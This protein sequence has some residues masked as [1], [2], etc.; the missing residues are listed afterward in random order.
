MVWQVKSLPGCSVV[1][2]HAVM[3]QTTIRVPR[4]ASAS[5]AGCTA[6]FSLLLNLP[7]TRNNNNSNN[8]NKPLSQKSSHQVPETGCCQIATSDKGFLSPSPQIHCPQWGREGSESNKEKKKIC[9]VHTISFEDSF[10][11]LLKSLIK[12]CLLGF[13][14]QYESLQLP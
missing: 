9:A 1:L 13:S 10:L 12:V 14:Q 8:N 3:P 7:E 4:H 5:P 11:Y 6:G 2:W